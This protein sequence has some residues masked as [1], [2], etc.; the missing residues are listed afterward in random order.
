M[1]YEFQLELS[2]SP[3]IACAHISDERLGL[4]L[5]KF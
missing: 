2:I 3:F 1:K 4:S 5:S